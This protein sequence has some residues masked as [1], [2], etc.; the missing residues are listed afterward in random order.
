MGDLLKLIWP[1]NSPRQLQHPAAYAGIEQTA[2]TA[3][4]RERSGKVQL[5]ELAWKPNVRP[6]SSG[7]YLGV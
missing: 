1:E 6:G 7:V 4:D 2:V 3:G 5:E